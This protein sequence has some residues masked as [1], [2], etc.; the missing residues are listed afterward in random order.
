MT[1]TQLQPPG[2]RPWGQIAA[3]RSPALGRRGMV[4]TSQSLASAA[5]LGV[6][7][8]GGNAVDAALTAAGVL[9]VIEPSMTGIGGDL[10]ALVYDPATH[11]VHGLDA[12]GRA[13]AAATPETYETRGL[14]AVPGT[15]P[16]AVNVPGVVSGWDALASRF[17]SWTL[18]RILEPA[19][20]HARDGF[21]VAELMAFEWQDSAE[22][23]SGD[24]SATATFLPNGR[25]PRMGEN[26][27][28][29]GLATSLAD[30]A[31]DGASAFYTGPIAEAIDADMRSRG[32]LLTAQDLAAH[33]ADWVE[34]IATTYRGVELCEMPPSTQGL[35]ALEMLNILEGF[36]LAAMGHNSADYLHV[37][38]EA[39]KIAFADRGAY[40]ADRAHMPAGAL[41][42]LTS[43]TYAA[44]RRAEIDM[45]R[46][47][48]YRPG[49]IAGGVPAAVDFAGLDRGD[50]V[51]LTVADDRGLVVSFIQSL[52]ASF[53]AG[54]VAGRTGITLNSRSSGFVL[55]PSHP[56]CVGP[57]KRPLHTLVPAMLLQNGRPWVSFGV[58]GG[59]N[60]AQAHAQVV[61]KL[62]DFGMHV[63]AAG[64]SA[65]VRHMEQEL[66]VER[67]IPASVRAS[68]EARGHRLRDGRGQMG[69]YQ[70]IMIDQSTGVMLGGSDPRK[71][72]LAIGW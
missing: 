33:T 57:N 59:D 14:A 43:K 55:T 38:S 54:I 34:P 62:V 28:N 4:A 18:G 60:Q 42:T 65:R 24:A 13:P 26:F 58:M 2:D 12:C 7:Q 19:V 66:A 11:R 69:G 29:P 63:Q 21:P 71:D 47:K 17:G 35:V 5:A 41:E 46:A 67:G 44:A 3:T 68:L 25:A 16:L 23:L 51:Y 49:P 30:I 9:A 6:L 52:F 70:A 22:R 31:R 27:A 36:D 39:K 61:T 1:M 72:G 20:R 37:V 50:T 48:A 10:F 64:D 8:A 45:E 32:G 40:L 15:G 56:N 53:G